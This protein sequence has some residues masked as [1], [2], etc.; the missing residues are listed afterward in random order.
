MAIATSSP[1]TNTV[2][3]LNRGIKTSTKKTVNDLILTGSYSFSFCSWFKY[4]TG[5]IKA[6][7]IVLCFTP[8]LVSCCM[9]Q[10]LESHINILFKI[11]QISNMYSELTVKKI[12][13]RAKKIVIEHQKHMIG[14]QSTNKI[15]FLFLHQWS[16]A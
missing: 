3:T 2:Y 14:R 8:L 10:I 16:S 12:S 13:K 6:P 9:Q 1:Y 11:M 5:E 7:G 4:G 15:I